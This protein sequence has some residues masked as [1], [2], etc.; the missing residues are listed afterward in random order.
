MPYIIVK[1]SLHKEL[2]RDWQRRKD[3]L[4][5]RR[6]EITE[7]IKDGIMSKNEMNRGEEGQPDFDNKVQIYDKWKK[8]KEP[9]MKEW[10]EINREFKKQGEEGRPHSI[11]DIREKK[12][13]FD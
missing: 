6:M 11:D 10:N 3:F 2:P 5:K 4:H 8:D 1:G 9:L 7:Q 12:L 13:K